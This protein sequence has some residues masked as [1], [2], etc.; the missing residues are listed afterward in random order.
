MHRKDLLDFRFKFVIHGPPSVLKN[1]YTVIKLGPRYSIAP[2]KKAKAYLRSATRQLAEQWAQISTKPIPPDMLVQAS[3]VSYLGSRRRVDL[4]NSY[5]AVE[6]ALQHAGVLAND[7][8]IAS[9]DG[10]RRRYD[11][12]NPRVEITLT[13]AEDSHG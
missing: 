7:W 3:I 8:Q 4:S 11:K 2:D 1:R 12:A 13:P 10:S 5:Q 6:D 9:H